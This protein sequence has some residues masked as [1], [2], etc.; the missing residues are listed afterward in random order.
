M[1]SPWFFILGSK[2][3]DALRLNVGSFRSPKMVVLSL[4]LAKS[5][6]S[7]SSQLPPFCF[8]LNVQYKID[9]HFDGS[10]IQTLTEFIILFIPLLPILHIFNFIHSFMYLH[11]IIEFVMSFI[12]SR[13]AAM[14]PNCFC[15]SVCFV[16]EEYL[17]ESMPC[18][19]A[20]VTA[21]FSDSWAAT[22]PT[23]ILGNFVTFAFMKLII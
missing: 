10:Y 17:Y 13:S 21:V 12:F 16:R 11:T 4:G 7:G 9:A 5:P 15:S 8:K 1:C 19:G 23:V 2:L 3:L 18:K 22:T 14:I 6:Q 20:N